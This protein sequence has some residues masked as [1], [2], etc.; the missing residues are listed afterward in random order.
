MTTKYTYRALLT[1]TLA[2]CA[3]F[4]YS[5]SGANE[6]TSPPNNPPTENVAAPINVSNETQTKAGNF[7]AYILG[8]TEAVWSP[9]YCNEDGTVCYDLDENTSQSPFY[10]C[11]NA[12]SSNRN[13]TP[14]YT[15]ANDSD[16]NKRYRAISCLYYDGTYQLGSA[17]R[18]WGSPYNAWYFAFTNLGDGNFRWQCEDGTVLVVETQPPQIRTG[19]TVFPETLASPAS[20]TLY[21]IRFGVPAL[22]LEGYVTYYNADSITASRIC[23]HHLS[24]PVGEWTR[25]VRIEG[26]HYNVNWQPFG[27]LAV[28]AWGNNGQQRTVCARGRDCLGVTHGVRLACYSS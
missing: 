23:Q 8:A 14:C 24:L 10:K 22:N 26:E 21:S 15:A 20:K 4:A 18:Y 5:F 12:D 6:W 27:N 28:T 19:G 2:V 9:A 11:T 25:T 7:G 1:T 13:N 17:L 3:L 16:F